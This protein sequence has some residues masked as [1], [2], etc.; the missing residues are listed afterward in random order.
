VQYQ[1]KAVDC[2]KQSERNAVVIIQK[3]KKIKAVYSFFFLKLQFT[4]LKGRKTEQSSHYMVLKEKKNRANS[5][6]QKGKKPSKPVIIY[7]R[8][9]EK[10]AD[11]V[12]SSCY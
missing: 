5:I 7:Y 6:D 11:I 2:K 12:Q 1:S 10:K 9:V 3:E 8:N 4:V